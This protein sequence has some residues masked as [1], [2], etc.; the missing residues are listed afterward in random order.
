MGLWGDISD[1]INDAGKW[2][3][4]QF[5]PGYRDHSKG[6][7]ASEKA[8]QGIE[9]RLI[10]GYQNLGNEMWNRSVDGSNGAQRMFAPSEAAYGGYAARGP[11]QLEA[12]YSAYGGQLAGPS[13]T[14]AVNRDA[15]WAFEGPSN[16]ERGYDLATDTLAG[17][18][19]TQALAGRFDA[20]MGNPT[21][22][23][24]YGADA[25]GRLAGPSNMQQAWGDTS[26]RLGSQ[27]AGERFYE[28]SRG[29]L[30]SPGMMEANAGRMAGSMADNATGSR[31]SQGVLTGLQGGGGMSGA[32][33]AAGEARGTINTG[34]AEQQRVRDEARGA[35]GAVDIGSRELGDTYRQ[36]GYSQDFAGSQL[37]GL[38]D[39]SLFE[40][41]AEAAF[42]GNDPLL[43][44]VT[45]RG[46]DAINQD[47]IAK[48]KFMSGGADAA[49]GNYQAEMDAQ[50]YQKKLDLARQ[51]GEAQRQRIG[52]GQSLA[53]AASGEALQ[54]GSALQGLGGEQRRL[55]LAERGFNVDTAQGNAG[56]GLQ[57]GA[58]ADASALGRTNASI[59]AASNV[60]RG[61]LSRAQTEADIYGR[62][63]DAANS[64]MQTG[65]QISDNAQGRDLQRQGMGIDA[66]QGMDDTE[67]ARMQAMFGMGQGMDSADMARWGMAGDL[68]GRSDQNAQGIAGQQFGMGQGLDEQTINELMTRGSLAGQT[69]EQTRQN[70]ALMFG[71]AAG[72]QGASDGRANDIFDRRFGMDKA[73][74]DALLPYYQSGANAYG[75]ANSAA[76]NALANKYGIG[77]S[78]EQNQQQADQGKIKAL[79]AA[80][81]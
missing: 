34:M 24:R 57:G 7:N 25:A 15:Y 43:D 63:Q 66:M 76:M 56:I 23:S 52:A 48:G 16:T 38:K 9:N 40:R 5:V 79:I 71:T 4:T 2:A 19:Q 41:Q 47:M 81:G 20:S 65:G 31:A 64:R 13:A 1:G 14:S 42:S 28:D 58:A 78:Q 51:S 8:Q 3:G 50:M 27:G 74:S 59:N 17:G 44:R 10:P 39:P 54:R 53:G 6:P 45:A 22:S 72:A 75:D 30:S 36:A 46:R 29:A 21:A 62:G 35:P 55:E 60:D 33:T 77:I 18:N 70:L 37:G 69:D 11:G 68:T 49:I 80:L 73:R 67:L 12:A 32:A 26:A 61:D